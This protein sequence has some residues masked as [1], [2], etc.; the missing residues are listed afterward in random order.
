VNTK[1]L[2]ALQA[3]GLIQAADNEAAGAFAKRRQLHVEEALIQMGLLDEMSLLKFQ[4]NLYQTYFVSTR[5]LASAPIHD[6]LLKLVTHKLAVKL[7]VFPVKF[8]A[9]AQEL[10][11][12]TVQ[13]DDLD[14]LKAVQFATR[15]PKVRAL[16]ARPAAIQAAIKVHFEGEPQAFGQIRQS[17]PS[18]G[19]IVERDKKRTLS[20][21]QESGPAPPP[22]R[23]VTFSLPPS[24]TKDSGIGLP[25]VPS[26]AAAPVPGTKHKTMRRTGDLGGAPP[27]PPSAMLPPLPQLGGA[28]PVQM[29]GVTAMQGFSPQSVQA[30]PAVLPSLQP[31]QF[32]APE[33]SQEVASSVKKTLPGVPVHDFLETLNVLVALLENERGELRSHSVQVARICRRL[34]ERLGIR[35]EESDAIIMAAY[36]HD[37]GKASALHLTALNVGEY[38]AHRQQA[39]KSYL[40]PVRLFESVRLPPE[41]NPILSHLYERFDGQGFPDR[42]TGK[43]ICLGARVMAIVETYADLVGHS[44]NPFRKKLTAQEAWDVL[45]KYKGKIFD[46]GLVD[47]FKLVVLGD[48]LRAKLLA[49]SRRALLVDPDAEE[50]TVLELRLAEHGFDVT[51]ARNSVDAE[52]ELGG[53]FDVVIS[54]VDI[55]PLNGFELLQK[56]RAGGNEVPFVFHSKN[57]EGD[58]V[59]RGFDLGAD[60]FITKPASPELVALKVT[61]VLDSAGKA[62]R[63]SGGVSG[64]LTEM[65]LPDVVQILYHGRKSG[66][67]TIS[68][69]GKRGEIL[70]GEGMIFDCSFGEHAHEEAFYEMLRLRQGDFELDPNFRPTEQVIQVSPESLLLEG[71]RRFDEHSR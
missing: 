51:I 60:D 57:A 54:E 14:V 45:A 47:V 4:A 33:P 63:K 42:L 61:R 52:N 12:I 23:D 50:T 9:K 38:E 20:F 27:P 55:K 58:S 1:L 62:K 8:D 11:I 3:A 5:K 39:K 16:V 32:A 25:P 13:P 18:T 28:P 41:V 46:P 43:E 35:Q 44:A 71:M 64:S 67:L 34:C 40:T 70:F 48:D 7:C 26:R 59:Q 30:M 24:S 66:K 49:D 21:E 2:D 31:H 29:A 15:V 36:L 22:S 68:A 37:V 17:G 6:A 10:S 65:A 53:D 56:I 19:L 69:D